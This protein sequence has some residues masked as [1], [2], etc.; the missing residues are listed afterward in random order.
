MFDPQVIFTESSGRT[1]IEVWRN[2]KRADEEAQVVKQGSEEALS[3]EGP[4]V[5]EERVTDTTEGQ[6]TE[7]SSTEG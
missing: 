5:K 2:G 3:T 6:S 4:L 1:V 7:R